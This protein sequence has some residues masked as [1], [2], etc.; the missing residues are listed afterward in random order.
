[1]DGYENRIAII[2]TL[3]ALKIN[4]ENIVIA[5]IAGVHLSPLFDVIALQTKA[6]LLLKEEGLWEEGIATNINGSVKEGIR[7]GLR[8]SKDHLHFEKQE[9]A[10][11]WKQ[12]IE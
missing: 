4:I 3:Q 11:M 10:E 1:M 6:A 9:V 7:N 2:E 12:F 8:W 5:S